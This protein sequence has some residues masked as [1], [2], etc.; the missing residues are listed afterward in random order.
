[1]ATQTIASLEQ[2]L[3]GL[4]AKTPIPSYPAASVLVRPLDIGRSY[5]A[6]ILGGI[7]ENDASN[8]FGSIAL[9]KNLDPGDL[10]V[11]LPQ[12]SH[13][14]VADDLARTIMD[15]VSTPLPTANS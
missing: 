5:L 14:S 11:T 3:G 13:G 2:L 15:K 9:P 4:G 7:V 1:M 10:V 12:L 8:A 6:D